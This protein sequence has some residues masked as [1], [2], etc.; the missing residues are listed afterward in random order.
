MVPTWAVNTG[1]LLGFIA[2]IVVLCITL[3]KPPINDSGSGTIKFGKWEFQFSGRA[4]FQLFVGVLLLTL[5]VLLSATAKAHPTVPATRQYQQVDSIP[6][7][8]H[9]GFVFLRDTSIL[10]LRGLAKSSLLVRMPWLSQKSNPVNLLNTM[11]IRKTQDTNF[12]SFTYGTSGKLDVRCL[13]H[14]CTFRRAIQADQHEN[15]VLNE[16]WELTAD[17]SRV[18]KGSEFELIVEATYWNAFDTPEK[19]WYATYPNSQH[20]PETVATLVLFPENKP[21][22]SYDTLAYPHGSTAGTPFVGDS[23]L[24]ASPDRLSL[25]WEIP[26]SQGNDTY[27]LH[28][29][30]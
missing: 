14:K 5:P 10:D 3:F 22:A 26:D 27:E 29:K 12:I 1:F 28:W 11:T 25:Y 6:D 4:I 18:P 21:F 2:G 30:F 13:T 17:V 20:E 8:V 9:T 24:A 23:H 7:P 16:T 15:G 19:Q